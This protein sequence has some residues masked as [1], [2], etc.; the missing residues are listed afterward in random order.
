ML[1]VRTNKLGAGV[2]FAITSIFRATLRISRQFEIV[3]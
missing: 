2:D 1:A 3:I